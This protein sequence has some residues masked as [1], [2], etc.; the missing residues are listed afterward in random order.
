MSITHPDSVTLEKGF[1]ALPLATYEAGEIVLAAGS[2][3][4]RLLFLRK[5]AAAVIRDGIEIAGCRN[6]ALYSA[7]SPR[8]W[9]SHT[10]RTCVPSRLPS[11]TSG[12]RP[13]CKT[14]PRFTA[15]RRSWHVVLTAPIRRSWN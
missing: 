7:K 1:A 12:M 9:I 13:L 2:K 14:W 15:L 3:T 6:L 10:Q 4:G 5:G 11:F 8:C